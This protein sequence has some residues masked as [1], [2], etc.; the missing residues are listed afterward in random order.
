MR[1][2]AGTFCPRPPRLECL[3]LFRRDLPA[4]AA[5][6]AELRVAFPGVEVAHHAVPA[7][8]TSARPAVIDSRSLIYPRLSI[9]YRGR[10]RFSNRTIAGSPLVPRPVETPSWCGRRLHAAGP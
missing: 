2:G 6:F 3:D 7:V 4:E 9:L 5:G 1:R 10:L 8:S